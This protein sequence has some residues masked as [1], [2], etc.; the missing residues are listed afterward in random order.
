MSQ[1]LPT[2][3]NSSPHGQPAHASQGTHGAPATG[4]THGGHGGADTPRVSA[5]YTFY[6]LRPEVFS[7]PAEERQRLAHELEDVVNAA[8]AHLGLLR[9]YSL[10]G[11]RGDADLLL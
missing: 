4:S 1:S 8:S 5:A 11:L 2:T 6:R 3:S 9:T 10:V 7:L